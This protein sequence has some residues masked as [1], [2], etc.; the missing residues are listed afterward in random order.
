MIIGL[1]FLSNLVRTLQKLDIR[2]SRYLLPL[3]IA[4][5]LIASTA[6]GLWQGW[7]IGMFCLLFGYAA[8]DR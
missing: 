1:I 6:Y 4:I 5:M 8:L 2:Y 7:W 3:F